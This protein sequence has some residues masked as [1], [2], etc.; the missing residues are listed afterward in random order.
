MLA[1]KFRR[2]V[3]F[4]LLLD[5]DRG[6]TLGVLDV[7]GLHVAVELL[8]GTLL[9]V[10]PPGNADAEPVGNALDAL[11]P[12]LL[13]ELGVDADIGGTHGLKREL[14]DLLDGLGGT[15]LEGLAVEAAVHV[16]GVLASDDVRNGGALAAGLLLGR[17]LDRLRESLGGACRGE[18][19]MRVLN[20]SQVAG[21]REFVAH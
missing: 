7:H 8:L 10:S 20:L 21:Q 9:V 17:H 19:A 11:L 18:L 12:D 13:V 4:L 14:L 1:A 3:L 15:L 6:K 2:F 5:D 16:D